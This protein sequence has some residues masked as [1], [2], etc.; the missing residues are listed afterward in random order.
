MRLSLLRSPKAPDANCDIGSHF[1]KYAL[2]PHK[3]SFL[4]SDVVSK[5]YLY[6]VPPIIHATPKSSHDSSGTLIERHPLLGQNGFFTITGGESIVLDTVK[7]AEDP[8]TVLGKDV[9]L[10][11]YE[12]CGGRGSLRL[13]TVWPMKEVKKCNIL[14]DLN[15]E[16]LTI[17]NG[18]VRVDYQPFKIIS[19]RILF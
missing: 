5:A 7:M 13:D 12:A 18:G 17:V 15:G 9:I 8:R 2:Y 11:F 19:L 6:N 1:F 10:R 4:E 16:N 3:G 14:E